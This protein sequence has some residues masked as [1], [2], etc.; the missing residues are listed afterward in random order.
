[1]FIRKF[2]QWG[3][4]TFAAGI[5]SAVALMPSN[6]MAAEACAGDAGLTKSGTIVA[7]A[8]SIGFMAGI[9]W[10]GGEVTLNNGQKFKFKFKGLKVL[11]TGVAVTDFV[12]E[13]YNL[14]KV[15]DFIGVYY[16]A[17][18]NLKIIKGKGEVVVNNSKCVVVKA[19][20][21]GKGLQLSAPAPGGVYVQLAE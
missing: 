10:G 1:M 18:S 15:E 20:A 2:W 7:T 6:V 9:R 5:V 13:V 4:A 14:K 11:D 12:G 21:S 8:K 19:K 3:A 16:G 17:A